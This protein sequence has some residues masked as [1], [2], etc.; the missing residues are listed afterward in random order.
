MSNTETPMHQDFPG[1]YLTVGINEDENRTQL[2]WEGLQGLISEADNDIIETLLRLAFHSKQRPSTDSVSRFRQFFRGADETFESSGNEREL[3]VLAGAALA[4]MM[5]SN[6]SMAARAALSVTTT[7]LAG[8]RQPD[9]PFDIVTLAQRAIEI[10]A[11]K[12][13]ARPSLDGS[14]SATKI[15][16]NGS[17]QKITEAPNWDGVKEAIKLVATSAQRELNKI[18][19]SQ[20]NTFGQVENFIRI[21]DEELQMLWRLI[22]RRSRDYDCSFDEVPPNTR[23]LL[24]AVELAED[25][26]ILPGPPS[27][28][29]LLSRSGIDEAKN[30]SIVDAVNNPKQEWLE[31]LLETFD[32]SPVSLPL[33]FAIKRQL[34]T[35][36]GDAW[37]A[38]W[39]A[40]TEVDRDYTLSTLT[41]S[42][43]FYRERLLVIFE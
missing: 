38:G 23:P 3:Q 29:A 24:H 20:K 21:Q 31:S 2:R 41:L 42:E 26:E 9:L 39:S 37:V 14:L 34:E 33:H 7:A 16:V 35:G 32:P 15:D 17:V 6:E 40:T 12:K 4:V 28:K 1:W 22:G 10:V 8:A 19:I 18:A 25:T 11:E 43:L 30:I 13:R 36:P 5:E 27:I